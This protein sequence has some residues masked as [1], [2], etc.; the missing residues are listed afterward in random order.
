MP[1][2]EPGV[3][4]GAEQ[5]SSAGQLLALAYERASYAAFDSIKERPRP[6]IRQ[7]VL[8]VEGQQGYYC[9]LLSP[10]GYTAASL[11]TFGTDQQI[12]Y[13]R[14]LSDNQLD[15]VV[16]NS[17]RETSIWLRLQANTD[18]QAVRAFVGNGGRELAGYRMP[19]LDDGRRTICDR[20]SGFLQTL[21]AD[22]RV[23]E[24][25]LYG[26]EAADYAEQPPAWDVTAVR[27]DVN[28]NRVAEDWVDENGNAGRMRSEVTV[29]ARGD[30]VL[31]QSRNE[32]D[33]SD[34]SESLTRQARVIV[35]RQQ[36]D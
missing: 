26:C 31:R 36:E 32:S 1:L 30:W 18:D 35:Y 2:V 11:N 20:S 6:D 8:T 17:D 7:L 12:T 9:H 27:Y 23:L 34:A 33:S 15:V 4:A 3:F 13:A 21:A 16:G 14:R 10:E 22:G 19:P 24:Q 5:P 29:N 28:D 25:Q